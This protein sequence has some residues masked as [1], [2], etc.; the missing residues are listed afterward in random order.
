MFKKRKG[1]LTSFAGCIVGRR[2]SGKTHLCL[3]M[4]RSGMFNDFSFDFIVFLS[5]TL[6]IQPKV[7]EKISTE[8]ILIATSLNTR[9]VKKLIN[10]Q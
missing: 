10:Y 9:L 3:Q 4:L 7:W 5:P 6:A 2:R 8:G 1:D